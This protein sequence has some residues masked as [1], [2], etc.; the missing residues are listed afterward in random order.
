LMLI[1][2]PLSMKYSSVSINRHPS[3]TCHH[4]VVDWNPTPNINYCHFICWNWKKAWSQKNKIIAIQNHIMYVFNNLPT[5]TIIIIL[6]QL[7][8]HFENDKEKLHLLLFNHGPTL[9]KPMEN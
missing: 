6:G 9:K 4:I 7:V 2:I 8:R 1:A 3:P 5:Y